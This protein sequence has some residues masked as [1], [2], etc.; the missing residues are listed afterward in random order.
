MRTILW[1]R[2]FSVEKSSPMPAPN[3]VIIDCTSLLARAR[4]SRAFS[5]LRIFPRKGKM[6]WV[7]GFRPC[8]ADPPAES[9]STRNIS[10]SEGSLEEQSRSLPG[11]PPDSSRPFRRVASRCCRLNCFSNNIA[12][13]G[14]VPFKPIT[15]LIGRCLLHERL[16]LGVPELG[17]SLA[18]KLRLGK[19]N[20][21]NSGQTLADIITGQ[22]IV[23]F[24]NDVLVARILIN[25]RG[26]R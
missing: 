22:V 16:C 11:I 3:A 21:D 5:T 18:L 15:Q 1:Y 13:L 6:A 23:F 17:L 19:F 9:P 10:D 25:K 12:G 24:L 4:S 8:T 2:T 7:S 20:R 26:Q 14:G